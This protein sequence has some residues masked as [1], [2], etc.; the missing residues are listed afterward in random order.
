MTKSECFILRNDE[1]ISSTKEGSLYIH[2]IHGYNTGV[3]CY[4]NIILA[5]VSIALHL[6]PQLAF[7]GLL[8]VG[9]LLSCPI[10]H[11]PPGAIIYISLLC[12]CILYDSRVMKANT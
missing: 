3:T 9:L 4:E 8:Y 12:L 6:F 7:L 1:R 5:V 10:T 11:K 2:L